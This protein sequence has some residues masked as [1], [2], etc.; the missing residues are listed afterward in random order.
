[1]VFAD[2]RALQS[3]IPTDE[4]TRTA[5]SSFVDDYKSCLE[6]YVSAG[7][8]E[9]K[10]KERVARAWHHATAELTRGIV[11]DDE[12][13]RAFWKRWAFG[14]FLKWVPEPS[15]STKKTRPG[16]VFPKVEDPSEPVEWHPDPAAKAMP[17]SEQELPCPVTVLELLL[18]GEDGSQLW[19]ARPS[20]Y[21]KTVT[22]QAV[23]GF[24]SPERYD[25]PLSGETQDVYIAAAMLYINSQV[26]ADT[27]LL[28]KPYPSADN[29]RFP[30][31]YLADEFLE[32][33]K[34]P[35][36]FTCFYILQSYQERIPSGLLLQLAR[37]M[38]QKL[39]SAEKKNADHL[40][41]TMDVVI[42]LS[43]GER[44]QIACDVV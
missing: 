8:D 38:L 37:S 33:C 42:L 13:A 31:V 3:P 40:R 29:P 34:P 21:R 20:P 27:S 24:W 4:E 32:Q 23:P 43:R 9:E 25:A 35:S 7:D 39:K 16:P 28:R 19:D 1:V 15:A 12:Q 11:I 5:L 22:I 6:T 2:G 17:S 18:Q 36:L 41:L 26:G 14:A 30:A 10:R 44:P